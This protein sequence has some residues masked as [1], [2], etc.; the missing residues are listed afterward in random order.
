[1][2]EA[3]E[4]GSRI[5]FVSVSRDKQRIG[6]VADVRGTEARVMDRLMPLEELGWS[7][8]EWTDWREATAA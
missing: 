1:M 2:T 8:S 5:A 6:W 7:W 3:P 4:K